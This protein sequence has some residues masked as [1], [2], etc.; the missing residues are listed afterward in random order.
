MAAIKPIAQ[1]SDKWVRRA[2]VAAPDYEQGVSNPR[3][4]WEQ[5]AIAAGA[6]YRAGVTAAANAGRFEAG[7]RSAG[8]D[9]WRAN[10]LAK[11]P[12]RYA[13][14]VQIGKGSWEEGFRP[15]QEAINAL[16][17]PPRGPKGSPNNLQRVTAVA[18]ALRQVRERRPS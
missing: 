2:G 4:S 15:Y 9:R 17:L 1:S 18:Q 11:G 7:V 14:G 8:E 13:E 3:A 10:S 12:T 5:S 16:R 6:N